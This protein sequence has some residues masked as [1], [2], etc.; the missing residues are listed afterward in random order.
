MKRIIKLTY[1]LA[2]LLP[3]ILGGIFFAES[4]RYTRG[5]RD[6][7][8]NRCRFNSEIESNCLKTVDGKDDVRFSEI[9]F[10]VIGVSSILYYPILYG[11]YIE[12]KNR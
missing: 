1:L 11:S 7:E 12:H 6:A 2:M 8:G 10:V 5:Y 9:A 4:S 3:V